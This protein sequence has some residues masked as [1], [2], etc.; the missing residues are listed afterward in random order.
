MLRTSFID[1][2]MSDADEILKNPD[3]EQLLC[4]TSEFF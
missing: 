3:H 4:G 2:N 1:V